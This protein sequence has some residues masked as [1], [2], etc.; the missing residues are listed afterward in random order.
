MTGSRKL[1]FGLAMSIFARS[2]FA[3]FGNSPAF[4]RLKRSRFSST[5]RSRHG[6]LTPAWKGV[7]RV[8]RIS[9]ADWSSTYASPFS[10]IRS[11]YSYIFGKYDEANLTSP[12]HLY[13]SHAI[14]S[15]IES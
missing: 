14:S 6:E 2:T 8:A 4:I 13:P 5:L 15:W 7:P 12:S 11:A 3:P 9:S 1:I 10:I